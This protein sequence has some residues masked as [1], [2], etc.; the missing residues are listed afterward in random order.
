MVSTTTFKARLHSPVDKVTALGKNLKAKEIHCCEGIIFLA[1]DS[2]PI[3]VIEFKEGSIYMTNTEKKKKDDLIQLATTLNVSPAG[4]V[5]EITSRLKKYSE[6]V[7]HHYLTHTVRNDEIHFWDRVTQPSF[8]AMFCVDSD[9]IYAAEVSDKSIISLQIEKDGVVVK[10]MNFQAIVPYRPTW[11]KVNSM[12][13]NSGNLFLSHGQGISTVNLETCEYRLAVELTNQPCVLT[14]F[15]E[16]VLYTNQTKASVWQLSDNGNHLRLFAG[17]DEEERS[18]D[19]PV[20]ECRFK[21]PVGI[22][23]EFASVVYVCD[24]Q[25]NSIKLCTKL[26]ERAHFLKAIGCLYEA[27]SVHDR[28]AHFSVKSSEEAIG[29]V[30]QCRQMLDENTRD[31]QK[32]TGIHTTLN[33]PQ[34]HVSARTVASVAMIDRSTE[35]AC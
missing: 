2:G 29:L 20:K 30:G 34:G 21:Q 27:F 33:G 9:L 26:Q 24:A 16:D 8:E 17:S 4:T 13:L 15:G 12:C 32:L 5:A 18:T 14:S 11:K 3:K 23:S 35:I 7:K 31:I 28:G 10:G 22:C 6:A 25:T 19:G 1:S